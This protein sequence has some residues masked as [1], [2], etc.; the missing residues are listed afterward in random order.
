MKAVI[1]RVKR[2]S[3]SVDRKEVAA[4]GPGL[5]V[6]L[7]VAAGDDAKDAGLLARKLAYIRI[8]SDDKGLMNLSISDI[9]GELLMVSQFTLLASTRKG[10]RP[11][12]TEAAGPEAASE[13]FAAVAGDLRER[14]LKVKTGVFGAMMSVELINDG[15]VTIIMDTRERT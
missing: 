2:A 10:N 3:V 7:G 5:L 9:D 1:Q 13:L 4:I 15:P 12:F 14:G 11:S 6:L 8:F